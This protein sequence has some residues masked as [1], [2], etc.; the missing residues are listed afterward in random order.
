MN[1]TNQAPTPPESPEP[2]K[3]NGQD[4]QSQARLLR[5]SQSTADIIL[6]DKGP[7]P[8]SRKAIIYLTL[9]L[10]V[11]FVLLFLFLSPA[12][13]ETM[14]QRSDTLAM[15]LAEGRET[16]QDAVPENEHSE[17]A[18]P[19]P[20]EA[21][22]VGDD[23]PYKIEAEPVEVTP[24]A[25]KASAAPPA[26]PRA[27]RPAPPPPKPQP[28]PAP[29]GP[30]QQAYQ[31]LM[32]SKPV[33]ASMVNGPSS[34]YAYQKYTVEDKGEGVFLFNFQFTR[35]DSGGEEHFL[36]Q[37]NTASQTIRPIGLNAA[38]LDRLN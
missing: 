22:P 19:A 26:A 2:K 35:T 8:I 25:T 11:V 16:V 18:A 29:A 37:V 17:Q 33:F 31:L 20:R 14:S 36:W 34:Q 10:L 30:E 38:K 12:T 23:E 21:R 32:E 5:R 27:E 6:T 3:A 24:P 15:V 13:H 1:P 28:K 4:L 7:A 9:S